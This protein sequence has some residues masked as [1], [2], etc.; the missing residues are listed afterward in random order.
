MI[1]EIG[2][3][4][5]YINSEYKKPLCVDLEDV[6]VNKIHTNID[7]NALEKEKVKQKTDEDKSN[8]DNA[9]S[10]EVQKKIPRFFYNLIQQFLPLVTMVALKVIFALNK[11]FSSI[12]I[13]PRDENSQTLLGLQRC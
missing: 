8:N 6:K 10:P 3:K 7:I 11:T 13:L 9:A 2:L 1:G 4:S 5:K 12:I